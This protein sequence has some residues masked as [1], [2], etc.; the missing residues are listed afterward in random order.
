MLARGAL[1]AEL[2]STLARQYPVTCILSSVDGLATSSY[3]VL[4]SR[5]FSGHCGQH[6]TH[7]SCHHREPPSNPGGPQGQEGPSSSQSHGYDTNF[8]QQ[9]H[10]CWSCNHHFRRGGL[11]CRSCD[12]IQPV[13]GSLNYFE[14]LGLPEIKF[15]L[16]LAQLER[17]YKLLQWQ[18]HPDKTVTKT[19]EEKDYSA[20]HAA[21][22]NQAYGVLRRPLSRANY[23]LML[24]GVEAGEN[25]QGTIEDPELLM[26]ILELQEEVEMTSDAKQLNDILHDIQHRHKVV[27]EKLGA[28]FRNSNIPLATR[29]TTELTYICRLEQTI[30]N[31]L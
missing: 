18:L 11:I 16:D 4:H 14:V 19:E 30:I 8:H 31:K 21:L 6:A 17:R 20:E 26:E 22:L 23:M 7:E 28:A 27:V 2:F 9:E 3:G 1:V 12:K 25:F 10:A 5:A 29:L 24:Q 13:D 15:D